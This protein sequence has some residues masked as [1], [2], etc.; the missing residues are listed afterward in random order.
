MK[1]NLLLFFTL[2]T[3]IVF[4]T[5]Q[6][7]NAQD[8]YCGSTIDAISA[9]ADA[10]TDSL[11]NNTACFTGVDDAAYTQ[12]TLPNATLP[13]VSYVLEFSTGLPLEVNQTGTWNT[14]SKGL[15]AG[16]TV[17]VRAFTYDLDS[18]NTILDVAAA[19]VVCDLIDSQFPEVMPCAQIQNLHT[20]VND[21]MPGLQGLNEAL[22]LAA[23][24]TDATIFSA[25]T[26]VAV[27]NELNA[28][29]T[30]L[31]STV[32]F[33]FTEAYTVV[34]TECE[35][36]PNDLDT[37]GIAN[38]DEDVD[39]DGDWMND[40]TDGDGTP[41]AEDNDDDGDGILTALEDAGDTDGDGVTNALDNDDDNDGIPTIDEADEDRR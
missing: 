21:G 3:A 38:A 32:C 13:N 23:S 12:D 18:I 30:L 22:E 41:N 28:N 4:L 9:P 8:Y 24:L 31:N 20:G 34:I 35:V 11:G 36:N 2:V 15:Q 39:G 26:A 14:I 1:R 29:I 5:T 27:L 37:D 17:K 10:P 33:N 6:S 40:D 19:Q 25:D 7:A 16:D